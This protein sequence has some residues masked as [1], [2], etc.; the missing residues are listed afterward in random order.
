MKTSDPG[1]P[2]PADYYCGLL[3]LWREGGAWRASLQPVESNECIGFADVEHL[4]A[5]TRRLLG[6]PDD[7]D[8]AGDG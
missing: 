6:P 2:T 8:A 7:G 1:R 5:H 4:F 3:C